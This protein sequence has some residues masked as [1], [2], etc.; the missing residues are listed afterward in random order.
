MDYQ[1]VTEYSSMHEAEVAK[2]ILNDQGIPAILQ[3]DNCGGL[4][5]APLSMG[6]KVLV[7]ADS[8]DAANDILNQMADDD[9]NEQI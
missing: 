8:L 9:P 7:P 4:V 5:P 2:A 1:L 3:S 6:V